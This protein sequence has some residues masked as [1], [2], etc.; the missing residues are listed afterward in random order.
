ME[1]PKVRCPS[2]GD[3]RLIPEIGLDDLDVIVIDRCC[4]ST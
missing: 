4:G 2:M 1:K 3:F